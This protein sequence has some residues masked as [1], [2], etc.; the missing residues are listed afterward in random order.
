MSCGK[1]DEPCVGV[2]D[3]FVHHEILFKK[4]FFARPY[5]T[6][7]VKFT[8]S[9]PSEGVCCAAVIPIFQFLLV[10]STKIGEIL[11]SFAEFPQ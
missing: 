11:K 1:I 7:S 3:F 4:D 10:V 6:V 8:L 5:C 2:S 9:T